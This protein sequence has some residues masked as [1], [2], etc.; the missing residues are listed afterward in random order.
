M[1]SAKLDSPARSL[2]VDPDGDN[3]LYAGVARPAE[4]GI[5]VFFKLGE[6]KVRVCIDNH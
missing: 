4:H 3:V 1:L 5:E 2:D 6:I